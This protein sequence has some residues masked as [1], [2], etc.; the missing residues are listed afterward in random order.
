MVRGSR[1]QIR[2]RFRRSSLW[3]MLRR[4]AS[5]V[6]KKIMLPPPE[7]VWGRSHQLRLQRFTAGLIAWGILAPGEALRYTPPFGDGGL[8]QP[9]H[10]G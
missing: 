8:R 1:A 6:V 3:A 9:P 10:R 4:M 7:V 5:R 2:S